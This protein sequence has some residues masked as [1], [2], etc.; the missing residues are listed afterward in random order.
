MY[1][2]KIQDT[3]RFNLSKRLPHRIRH[4]CISISQNSLNIL[5]VIQL[6][7]RSNEVYSTVKLRENKFISHPFSTFGHLAI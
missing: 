6:S 4:I 7:I 5:K 2:L 1:L 3:I